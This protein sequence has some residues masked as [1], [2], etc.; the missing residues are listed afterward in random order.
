LTE[1]LPVVEEY[2]AWAKS[3]AP[4]A[5]PKMKTGEAV[6]YSIRQE[7]KLRAFLSDGRLEL[8]NNRAE[9][10]I[11][12]FVIGRKNWLFSNTP[13]GA[14]ASAVIYGI[15]ETAKENGL[16]VIPYLTHLFETLSNADP[17]DKTVLS[18][19]LPWSDSLP[20]ECGAPL[21]RTNAG[22]A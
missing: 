6:N 22:G 11:K 19:L 7:T 3:A 10:S 21:A 16:S 15:V 14:E 13:G 1:S 12:P 8:S 4:A 2:F 20:P 18:T 5:S 17:S 9:R